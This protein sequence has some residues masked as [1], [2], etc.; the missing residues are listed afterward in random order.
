MQLVEAATRSRSTQ[1]HPWKE[2]QAMNIYDLDE[3]AKDPYRFR[4]VL[5]TKDYQDVM[6]KTNGELM[7]AGYLFRFVGKALGAGLWEVTLKRKR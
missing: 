6:V 3:A 1:Q 5:R 7:A 4:K 2:V